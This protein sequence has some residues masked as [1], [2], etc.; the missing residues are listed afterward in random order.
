MLM[1]IEESRTF[2]KIPLG[3]GTHRA[4]LAVF[5]VLIVLG[6]CASEQKS[7]EPV[8]ESVQGTKQS[9]AFGGFKKRRD[10]DVVDFVPPTLKGKR[11]AG[12]G[13]PREINT[14]WSIV[15]QLFRGR[16]ANE[17]ATKGLYKVQQEAG[18]TDAFV[19]ARGGA[20]AILYGR[21]PN[22]EDARAKA[23]LDRIKNMVI[24]DGK[25]FEGAALA[26]PEASASE[27]SLA[28]YDLSRARE[29]FGKDAAYTLQVGVYRRM[30]G[31]DVTPSDLAEFRAAAEAAVTQLRAAGQE[32]FYYHGIRSSTV[33]V[34]IFVSSEI[35]TSVRGQNGEMQKLPRPHY[36]D[37]IEEAMNAN[38][39][40][41]VNGEVVKMRGGRG[42]ESGLIE[43]PR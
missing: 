17:F 12:K 20:L 11:L 9:N 34:G 19:E 16:S 38:P 26:P 1:P 40:N 23:D 25:P 31:E 24:G 41:L 43:I 42:Q 21:Y 8:Q 29:T 10:R 14:D 18:L 5:V 30:D 3:W 15:I 39:Y 33:T 4:G 36:S 37:R 2:F 27:G 13:E 6:G 35:V 28:E 7:P 32:A 22:P